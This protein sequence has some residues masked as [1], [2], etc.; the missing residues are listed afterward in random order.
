MENAD[1]LFSAF[2]LKWLKDG[3]PSMGPGFYA[4]AAYDIKTSIVPCFEKNPV[5]LLKLTARD[6]ESFF[7]YER[8]QNEATAQDLLQY[9]EAI[10]AALEYAVELGWIKTNPAEEVNPCVA[11]RF[12]LQMRFWHVIRQLPN[13]RTGQKKALKLYASGQFLNCRWPDSN[14][15]G[16]LRRILSAVRLPIPSH[17]QMR[18]LY[19]GSHQIASISRKTGGNSPGFLMSPGRTVPPRPPS[20]WAAP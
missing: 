11:A 13:S 20:G 17:R 8:Q 7:R 15:H 19:T 3:A 12:P 16:L 2:L 10:A 14:R 4:N 5:G 1:I 6:I 18:K 9:H